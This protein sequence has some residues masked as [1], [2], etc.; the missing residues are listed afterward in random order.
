MKR[1]LIA[2]TIIGSLLI[3]SAAAFASTT[4]LRMTAVT[5]ESQPA[6]KGTEA[7]Q[8]ANQNRQNGIEYTKEISY[9]DDGSVGAV[10][11]TW[12]DPVTHDKRIDMLAKEKD[13]TIHPISQYLKDNGTKWVEVSRNKSGKA[14]SGKYIKLTEEETMSADTWKSF[15][16]RKAEF[17]KTGW[18]NEGLLE[19]QDGKQLVK[20]SGEDM[21]EDDRQPEGSKVVI[22]QYVQI[23]KDLGLP[24]K[25]EAYTEFEGI[26]EKRYSITYENKYVDDKNLFD[27]TGIPM[28]EHKKLQ[29]IHGVEY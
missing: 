10:V 13:G 4:D 8:P 28:K 15:A 19:S 6:K 26:R 5:G 14:V 29:W 3:T 17:A 27:T 11:E 20:L 1:V 21:L 18:K 23:E 2:S 24:V 9:L 7:I 16:E 22:H 25:L 12:V